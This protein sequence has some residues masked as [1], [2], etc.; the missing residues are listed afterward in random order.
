MKIISLVKMDKGRAKICL[1]GGADFVLYKKEY[2]SYGLA[3]GEDLSEAS[4]DEI[5]REILIPR[6]KKRGLYLLQKQDRSRKNLTDKLL[7]GGYPIDVVDEAI[8]YIDSFGY[9][10]DE[11]MARS[12]I[13]FYQDS[14]SKMRIRQDLKKKGISD[15]VINIALEDEYAN[16]EMELINALLTKKHYDKEEASYEDKGKMYRFLA[17]RG[18]S[19]DAIKKALS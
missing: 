8:A 12:Y 5:K 2:M 14:R 13:R 17:S 10:D 4:Y 9:I 15:D 3:E 16:D 7:E 11:R 18:F 19:S 6:C 1:E